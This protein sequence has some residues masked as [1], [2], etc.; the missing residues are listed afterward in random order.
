MKKKIATP[1]IRPSSV[2]VAGPQELLGD[3]ERFLRNLILDL[4][5]ESPRSGRGRP[6]VLPALALWAGLLVCVLRGFHSQLALWRLLQA[7]GLWTFPRYPI[8]DQA[9]YNRL[10]AAGTA[11]LE[12][13]FGQ[14]ST[15]LADRLTATATATLAPFA[16]EVVALDQTTLD[17]LARR[18]PAL[19]DVPAGDARLLPG[20]LAGL[21]DIRRQQWRTV[22]PIADPQ[23]NEKVTARDL[24]A[25]LPSG[26]L[27]LADLGYFGFAWFDW[28]TD[29][30]YYWI[31][32][33]RAKTSYEVIHLAYEQG[34]TFDGVVWLGTHRADRAAHAVRLVRFRLGA[35]LYQY[36]TNVLDPQQLSLLEIARLYA[37]RWDFE[38]AVLLV[39]EHLGLH[40]FWSA[41]SVVAQQQVWAVLIIAQVLQALRLEIAQRAG[42][43]PFEVSLAL[44][45]QYLPRYA[46]EGHDP[47]AVF[48]E[49]GRVLRFIRPS[50]RTVIR[51]PAIPAEALRPL[52]LDLV[53][54]RTPRYAERKCNRQSTPQSN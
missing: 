15:V 36:V 7:G 12:R 14:V 50:R 4:E 23:Q 30:D 11:P 6:R 37:R 39:K 52:P 3:I 17:Q 38:L 25:T 31:S 44:L 8:S 20:K 27:I 22:Q 21:F 29:H 40:L 53:L 34:E 33:L 13:L 2:S 54:T 10:E 26:S 18:L 43:D 16:T 19:R 5:P 32:R 28:L 47:V 49:Y 46:A 1:E 24:V 51:G 35:V 42:V 41:K 48:V 45:V 9:V